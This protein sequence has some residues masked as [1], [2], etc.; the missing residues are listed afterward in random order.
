MISVDIW[1]ME[2]NAHIHNFSNLVDIGFISCGEADNSKRGKLCS[3]LHEVK[4][5]EMLH[6]MSFTSKNA[7]TNILDGYHS[8]TTTAA[9]PV[10]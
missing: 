5:T 8:L 2:M 1:I 3:F 7:A 9:P 10:L 6:E 4:A